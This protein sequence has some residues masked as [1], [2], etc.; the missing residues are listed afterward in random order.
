MKKWLLAAFFA[1]LPS[2]AFAQNGY[3]EGSVGLVLFP[4]IQSDNYTITTSGG[5]FQ[6]NAETDYGGNWGL[7]LEGGYQTGPWRFGLSWDWIRAEV[8]HAR[9]EGTLNGSPFSSELTDQQLEN[10]G[11][12]ANNDVNIFALN[13]Y[14]TFNSFTLLQ[15]GF[16]PYLGLGAGLATINNASSEFAFL[17]T[18]GADVLLGQG[19]YLGGRYRL[20]II[21]GP[22]TDR[23][24]HLGGF[25]TH[26][27]SLVLGYR[28]GV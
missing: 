14:Y 20:G 7:G 2:I 12:G 1:V 9:V 10:F 4:D 22:T 5:L 26:I 17:V 19:F 8:D 3:I 6:G 18:A 24:I 13:A 16:Q 23:D 27:F 11:I 21:S 25:T 15:T 28:F